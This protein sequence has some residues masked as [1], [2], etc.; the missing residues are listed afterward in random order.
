MQTK[1]TVSYIV[2]NNYR[3]E[4]NYPKQPLPSSYWVQKRAST[5]PGRPK[6]E[7]EEEELLYFREIG[8]TWVEI[9]KLLS[10]SRWTVSRRVAELGIS[11]A[12]GHSKITDE[13][14]DNILRNFKNLH[15]ITAGRSL[16]L[17]H[18]KSLGLRVQ[19]KRVAKSL[20][21]IDPVDSGIRWASLIRRR[22]Y[23]VPGPNS[24]W[25]IDGHH[26]LVNWGF[27]IHGGIDGFSRLIIFLRCSS[28]NKKETMLQLYDDAIN[29]CGCPSRV[30]T[31]KGGENVLVWD[32]II[33]L[34]GEDRGSYIAGSSVHNQRIERL[35]RDVWNYVSSQFYYTFQAM[36]EQGI[37]YV[38]KDKPPYILVDQRYLWARG[39]FQCQNNITCRHGILDT[40]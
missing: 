3:T 15:G 40:A 34:R 8:Y 37:D 17:G 14:L 21:R 38:L 23:S 35:W 4:V 5:G 16:A 6:Y 33:E 39:V 28:N 24:L 26:S 22:K 27:V 32:R 18:L 9:A 31:D 19:Q 25:H 10:V 30:R 2:D 1:R 29:R 20:V 36:E 12:T 11:N 7:I 13:E